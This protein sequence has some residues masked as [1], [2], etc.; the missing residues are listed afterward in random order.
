MLTPYFRHI[1]SV[2]VFLRFHSPQRERKVY[3][4][5]Y[6][7]IFSKCELKLFFMYAIWEQGKIEMREKEGLYKNTETDFIE[8][9]KAI[10][11]SVYF[12]IAFRDVRKMKDCYHQFVDCAHCQE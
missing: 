11:Y 2:L 9:F 4:G 3:P 7:N 10:D 12:R 6:L 5:Y 1:T 8:L